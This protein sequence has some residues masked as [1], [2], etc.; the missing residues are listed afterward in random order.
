MVGLAAISASNRCRSAVLA[1][2]YFSERSNSDVR[3]ISIRHHYTP[4]A[5][6]SKKYANSVLDRLCS[7]AGKRHHVGPAAA[8]DI[9]S[10]Y[11]TYQ[12]ENGPHSQ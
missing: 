4:V 10:G 6:L 2:S 5:Y 7:H 12:P 1:P 8:G 11:W 9:P 3:T